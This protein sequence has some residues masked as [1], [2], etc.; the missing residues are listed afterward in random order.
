MGAYLTNCRSFIDVNVFGIS[1]D[2]RLQKH[3]PQQSGSGVSGI[4]TSFIK[5]S[6]AAG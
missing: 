2:G 6:Y 1:A 5:S 4:L 3:R